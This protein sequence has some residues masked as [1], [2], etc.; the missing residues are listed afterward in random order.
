MAAASSHSAAAPVLSVALARLQARVYRTNL[1]W[2]A[3]VADLA[4]SAG[5]TS[6][7]ATAAAATRSLATATPSELSPEELGALPEGVAYDAAAGVYAQ[8]VAVLPRFYGAVIGQ[9]G[10]TLEKLQAETQAT[11]IVPG[12]RS[13]ET[14]ITL[15]A[16]TLA[17]LDKAALRLQLLVEDAQRRAPPTHFVS[18][19]LD[20]PALHAAV[21]AFFS[22][23][24]SLK[25]ASD[26]EVEPSRG[27]IFEPPLPFVGA[28][29]GACCARE[30]A[31][32]A[33]R[34]EAVRASGRGACKRG[35][36]ASCSARSRYARQA[37]KPGHCR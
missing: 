23:I 6:A 2:G 29:C 21:E 13:A 12:K 22:D 1:P 5:S 11:V 37:V 15:R 25:A 9:H 31:P 16:A 19:P 18:L 8:R 32:H 27:L 14:H 30:S 7:T 35:A 34:D 20:D 24:R 3:V 17:Q 10:R 26:G 36:G 33:G 28:G 4:N